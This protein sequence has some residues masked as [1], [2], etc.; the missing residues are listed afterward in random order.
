[1]SSPFGS[2]LG[3]LKS[4]SS[5]QRYAIQCVL[6]VMPQIGSGWDGGEEVPERGASGPRQLMGLES[7]PS[8]PVSLL[9]QLPASV[10]PLGGGFSPLSRVFQILLSW[11][12]LQP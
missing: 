12:Y 2:L 4:G 1:M 10:L 7:L 6:R 11:F 5:L 9:Q 3:N 8:P